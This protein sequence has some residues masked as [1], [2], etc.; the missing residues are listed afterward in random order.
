MRP[1][2]LSEDE[3]ALLKACR[4]HDSEYDDSVAEAMESLARSLHG[5]GAIPTPRLAWFTDPACNTSRRKGS[6]RQLLEEG[7]SEL[8]YFR[9]PHFKRYLRYFVFGPDLDPSI[10]AGFRQSL[11]DE[12]PATSGTVDVLVGFARGEVTRR[13]LDRSSAAEEFF[14]LA[15]ECGLDISMSHAVRNGVMR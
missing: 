7:G 12:G 9:K 15:L 4:I 6:W 11:A 13:R 14:K 10:V 1:I 2:E 8:P 3:S 5:R